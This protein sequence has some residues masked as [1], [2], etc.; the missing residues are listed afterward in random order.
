M[1]IRFFIFLY[2][3]LHLSLSFSKEIPV[4]VISAGKTPQSYS[5]VGSQISIIDA[6]T[7]KKS[8]GTTLTELLESESQGL[9]IFRLGGKGTN[10]GIQMR[11]LPKR[12]STVYVD[13]VKMY[14]PSASDNAF[15]AEGIFKDNIERIEILKGSQSS[16]YGNSAV[17]GTINIFTKRGE[18]GK[19]QK[20]I[21]RT[22]Q[23]NTKDIFYSLSGADDKQNYYIGFNYYV[24]E[25]ISAMNND[26]ERD[27]YENDSLTINYDYRISENNTFENSFRIKDSY[28]KYDEP[29]D[30]RDDTLNSTDNLEANYSFKLINTNNKLINTLGLSKSGS[31]R[32]VTAYDGKEKTYEGFRD[33]LTYLGE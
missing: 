30:G 33:M 4:I 20:A 32:M 9:N 18:L 28:L 25:G 23:K 26:N 24:T 27:P 21:L 22:S 17:G 13:G 11:G 1:L 12:Y 15:Y 14:D 8:T 5:T 3:L 16:L 29:T 2:F 10:T 6:E 31:S 7:I 19:Q